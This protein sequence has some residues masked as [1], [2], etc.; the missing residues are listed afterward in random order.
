[1]CNRARGAPCTEGALQGPRAV[2]PGSSCS[3]P[4]VCARR[5]AQAKP[6][7]GS[8]SQNQ[9]LL[10]GSVATQVAS[11]RQ[12]LHHSE[13]QGIQHWSGYSR[14]PH[15]Q[16]ACLPPLRHPHPWGRGRQDT[17]CFAAMRALLLL[18][19][20]GATGR[21]RSWKLL[22]SRAVKMKPRISMKKSQQNLEIPLPRFSE[23]EKI[24]IFF[25]GLHYSLVTAC[26]WFLRYTFLL[27]ILFLI[28][29]IIMMVAYG[30]ISL[31]L[32]RGIKFDASQRKSSRGKNTFRLFLKVR[33]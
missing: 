17:G 10:R 22:I 29:G 14:E 12:L 24:Y 1:M 31:E 18:C 19:F 11:A 15:G 7:S 3:V 4:P 16:R 21:R 2:S 13:Q 26:S 9:G 27:L 5:L 30:L 25:C 23:G 6:H 20:S 32:Y 28:P 8:D 33:A